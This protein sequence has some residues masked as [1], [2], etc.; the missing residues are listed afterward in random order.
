M[1][2]PGGVEKEAQVRSSAPAERGSLAADFIFP[3]GR[4]YIIRSD[5]MY[6]RRTPICT[7]PNDMEAYELY[8]KAVDLADESG[9]ET[10]A[11]ELFKRAFSM[12]R[13]LADLYGM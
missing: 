3:P 1:Q 4:K 12:S 7:L 13:N 8:R 11:L 6:Q 2:C 9:S 10:K 5:V